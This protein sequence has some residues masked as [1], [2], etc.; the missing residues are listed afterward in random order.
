MA[1]PA[2]AAAIGGVLLNLAGSFVAQ[3]LVS[4][5]ISVVTYTG[6]DLVLNRLKADA[7]QSLTGL[8][9]ELVGLLAYMQVGVAISIIT[10]AVAVRMGLNGMD[11]A[12]KRFRKK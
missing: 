9:A 7:I 11:G 4:L 1:L 12:V 8:P 5:A 3:V 10:S 6:V 2:I